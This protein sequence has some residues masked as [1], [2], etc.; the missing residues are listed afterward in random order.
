MHLIK[1][2]IVSFALISLSLLA[3][4]ANDK[5]VRAQAVSGHTELSPA[6]VNDPQI[7]SYLQSIGQRIIASAREFDAAHQGPKSHFDKKQNANWMFTNNMQF[8]LVNSKTLN[9][10]T[11][12]GEHMY[13]YNAL[14]QM[15]KNEDELAAVMAHE[16]AHVYSRH[17][18]RGENRQTFLQGSATVLG[19]AGQYEG[20]QLGSAIS[21]LG[22][23]GVQ[24]IG[25][26]YTRGQE[27]EADAWGF[28]FYSRAGWDPNHFADF[29]KDMIAAGYDTGSE[30]TSDHPKLS[31]RVANTAQ[32]VKQLGDTSKYRKP[33]IADPAQFAQL[34]QQAQADCSRQPTSDELMKAKALLASFASCVAPNDNQ[35][36]QVQVKQA[37]AAKKK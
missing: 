36:E 16:Y 2:T 28:Q 21:Q 25:L 8:H 6:V 31:I 5:S 29:F 9:A 26:G 27:D 33:P 3:G 4:C 11:T 32:R 22:P 12:G 34:K 35:P 18:Q 20:G 15:C 30:Y 19:A 17:V 24:L 37:L 10:F 7:N 23:A 13:I 1:P 14:F